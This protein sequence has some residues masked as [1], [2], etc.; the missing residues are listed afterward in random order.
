MSYLLSMGQPT[1]AVALYLPTSSLWLNDEAS[2]TAFV[3]TEQLLSE[4]QVDFDIVSEDAIATDLRA[5]HGAFKTLSGNTYRAVIIPSA[6]VISQTALDRLHT[7]ATGGGRVLFLG[8]TPTLISGKTI[9]N[10]RTATDADFAWATTETSAQ[11]PPT[12]TPP[13]QPPTSAPSP[14]V[15]PPSILNAVTTVVGLQAITLD[16]PDTTLRYMKRR[17]KDSDVY[18]LFNEGATPDTHAIT[19]HTDAQMIEIWNPE[20]GSVSAA[21]STRGEGTMIIQLAMK[22]YATTVLMVR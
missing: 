17:L 2:D 20:T 13:A 10:A 7:F 9:L 3:A 15:V 1:A 22:P 11:L 19:F 14:Q 6:A 5:E 12:P 8:R 16:T 4:H 18:L 21:I